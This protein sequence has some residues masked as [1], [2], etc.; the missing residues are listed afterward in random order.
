MEEIK[1][2]V[3][4]VLE[5]IPIYVIGDIHGDYQ[6]LVHCLVDLCNVCSIGSIESDI[7]FDESKREILE[8]EKIIIQ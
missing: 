8:W 1:T 4:K 2:G 6:C 3:F 7:K 5:N